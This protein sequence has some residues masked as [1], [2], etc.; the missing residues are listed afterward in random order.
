MSPLR[1]GVK[2]PHLLVLRITPD[3]KDGV[4]ILRYLQQYQQLPHPLGWGRRF[5]KLGDLSPIDLS[6]VDSCNVF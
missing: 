4:S 2:T 1:E 6:R 3:L 5:L